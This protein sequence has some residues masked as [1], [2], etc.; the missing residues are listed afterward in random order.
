M[1]KKDIFPFIKLIQRQNVQIGANKK[2]DEVIRDFNF[3]YFLR[4]S[5]SLMPYSKGDTGLFEKMRMSKEEYEKM[6][7]AIDRKMENLGKGEKVA[8]T[9]DEWDVLLDMYSRIN[10]KLDK[11]KEEKSLGS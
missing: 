8:Y 5:E 2:E 10:K 7:R 1:D 3:G 9:P 6:I 11:E 4:V